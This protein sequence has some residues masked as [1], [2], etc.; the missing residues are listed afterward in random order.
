MTGVGIAWASILA[1]PYTILAGC[2]P[3]NKIGIY[4]GVFNFA[5]VLPEITASLLFGWVMNHLLHNNRLYAVIAG[6][7]FLVFAA[8]L[9]QRVQ[10]VTAPVR[11]GLRTA[12]ETP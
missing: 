1:M 6:G 8:I 3:K 7:V 4:M 5:I 10:D 2:L 12:A 9:M 11:A